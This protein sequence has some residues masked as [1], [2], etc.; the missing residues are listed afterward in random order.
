MPGEDAY[1]A[2]SARK[3]CI[4]C[5]AC[6]GITALIWIIL[7]FTAEPCPPHIIPMAE[8][9]LSRYEGTWHEMYRLQNNFQDGICT[10][11]KYSLLPDG[12]LTVYNMQWKGT[13]PTQST[14]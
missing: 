11:A 1:E 2:K 10:T 5:G 12:T 14:R 9:D 8:L 3:I 13:K 6:I 4:G 7:A